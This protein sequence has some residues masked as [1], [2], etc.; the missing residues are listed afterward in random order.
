[1]KCANCGRKQHK[2]KL[3][4]VCFS[5]SVKKKITRGFR[6]K[7]T[8]TDKTLLLINDG[9]APGI[10]LEKFAKEI[11]VHTNHRIDIGKKLKSEYLL[12]YDKIFLPTI[13][14]EFL[15]NSLNS[16]FSGSIKINPD[17]LVCPLSMVS[18]ED[19]EFLANRMQIEFKPKKVRVLNAI[20]YIDKKYPGSKETLAKG[21][22]L[23]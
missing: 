10:L 3:C 19:V 8:K 16:I 15:N 1:M 6:G 5:R 20:D 18:L 17:K 13:L 4:E 11:L 9:S 7:L 23:L 22:F 2:N 14:E 12:K 21:L